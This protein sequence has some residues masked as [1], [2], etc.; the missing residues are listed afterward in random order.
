MSAPLYE[1]LRKYADK[2]RISFAMPGHKNGRGLRDNLA[3]LDVTEL[4]ETENLHR[5]GEYV[6]QA[7][8][9]LS[10]LYGSDKSYI[11]TNGSTAAIQSM[12]CASLRPGET[13][14][15]DGNCHM[16]VI[17]T[18]ALLGIN[19]RFI[20][21]EFNNDFHIPKG[22]KSIRKHITADVGAVIITSPSYYG[23][24]ADVEAI[25]K[26]CHEKNIPLLVDEAH[27]AHFIADA[28]LPETAVKYADA[29][30]QS[31]HKTLNAM[32]GAA[33]LHVNGSRLDKAR[34]CESLSMF[35]SSSPSYVI[36]ATADTAREEIENGGGW[37]DT[38]QICLE[39]R[40]GAEKLGVRALE[41]DDVTR[42][43][44]NFSNIGITGFKASDFLAERGIDVEAADFFNIIL[45][46]T[47]SNTRADADALMGALS[48][49]VQDADGAALTQIPE[50]PPITSEVLSPN[51]AFFAPRAEVDFEK[52]AGRTAAVSVV[53]YPPGVPVIH[54]GEEIRAEQIEYILRIAAAG[55]EIVGIDNGKI[56]VTER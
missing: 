4:P 18:C 5:G 3:A 55:A 16:S 48:E 46:V 37:G 11:L 47:P 53:P 2:N 45:I 52:S 22:L 41:N 13:L 28:R 42:L 39:L 30:C 27:G 15:A 24:C 26:E 54:T 35:Q 31:A 23:V 33:Y 1:R 32:N 8:G 29:V 44:L 10:R 34:L 50:M 49:L 7:Q 56:Q 38:A 43:V 12:I 21:I 51:K 36:A 17:N 19:I 6:K 9:L 14:L 20:P 40:R 25:A